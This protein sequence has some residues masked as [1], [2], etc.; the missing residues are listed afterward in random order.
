MGVYVRRTV[1]STLKKA[2]KSYDLLFYDSNED[3]N[4]LSI[5][6]LFC[7]HFKS[8]LLTKVYSNALHGLFNYTGISGHLHWL[9]VYANFYCETNPFERTDLKLRDLTVIRG[10]G[11]RGPQS[12]YPGVD[13]EHFERSNRNYN[14]AK[15]QVPKLE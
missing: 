12:Y 5:C 11:N 10:Q 8:K 4:A 3:V 1:G 15:N 7:R 14:T 9:E 6:N 2:P 13:P